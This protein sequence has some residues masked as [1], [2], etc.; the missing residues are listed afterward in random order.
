MNTEEVRIEIDEEEHVSGIL[1]LPEGYAEDRDT[2]ITVA[3][4]AGSDMHTTLLEAL[5][6][7]LARAGSP[8]STSSTSRAWGILIGTI[9]LSRTTPLS[10]VWPGPLSRSTKSRRR[11]YSPDSL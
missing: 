3:H 1:H 2:G 4:G 5:C 11:L 7:G 6:E 8:A 10:S 9:S